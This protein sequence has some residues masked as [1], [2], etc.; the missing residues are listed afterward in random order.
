MLVLSRKPMERI[1]IGDNIVVTVVQI[2][3]NRVRIGIEAPKEIHVLR[4][5]LP[6]QVSNPPQE[7]SRATVVSSELYVASGIEGRATKGGDVQTSAA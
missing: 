1:H 3:G 7:V 2:E 5:E 6:V 4:S